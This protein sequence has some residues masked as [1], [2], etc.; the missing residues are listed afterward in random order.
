M[1]RDMQDADYDISAPAVDSPGDAARLAEAKAY[2]RQRLLCHLMDMGLDLVLLLIAA[3]WIA[4]PAD[5]WLQESA[6][7]QL[8][9]IRLA[10]FFLLLAFGQYILGLPLAMYSGY[11]LEHRF[12]LSRQTWFRWFRRSLL[13]TL[14]V[15]F[16]GLL[17]SEGLFALIWFSGPYWWLIAA[18][19]M[20]VVSVV[21]GQLV[22]VLILPL[23][24]EIERLEDDSLGERFARLTS[25]TSLRIEGVY[26]M[27][28]SDETVKANA[29]LA[30][31]GRTRR[32]I[33]GDTLLDNFPP[34]EID[35]VFAHEVG[36]HVHRH[37]AKLI[38]GGLLFSVIGFFL[39]DR[40]L[41]G[42]MGGE[43]RYGDLSVAALPLLLLVVTMFSLVT[44]PLQNAVSR[45]FEQQSDR[46]ALE[47]TGRPEA[48]R[49]AFRRLATLN[50]AD[51]DPHW[52]EV[53]LFHD[54]P[55]IA[56]RLALAEMGVKQ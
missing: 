1:G 36:H 3:F 50:K 30:G 38:T 27:K 31:L 49:S 24:Y 47:A 52:L 33:L 15:V 18:A 54:H 2:G 10:A 25:G 26:R 23:F 56:Q 34:E 32:V 9:A 6:W 20:F 40:V 4:E 37:I 44:S 17:L 5:R 12:G 22:P 11:F 8:P 43:A 13:K 14:L 48:Y 41:V 21:L 55:P 46:Y 35:V 29:M 39:C 16:F 45:Y 28:L 19:A 7:L 53:V 51:P 42:W